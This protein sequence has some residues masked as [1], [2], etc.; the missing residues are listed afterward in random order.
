MDMAGFFRIN[1]ILADNMF[2]DYDDSSNPMTINF[3]NSFSDN[4]F[5]FILRIVTFFYF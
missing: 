2:E 1:E 3:N 5:T 4:Y